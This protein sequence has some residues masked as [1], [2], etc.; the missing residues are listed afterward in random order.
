MPSYTLRVMSKQILPT[1][2]QAKPANHSNPNT[3]KLTVMK[4]FQGR[5]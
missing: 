5:W 1:E 2:T 3:L 4:D